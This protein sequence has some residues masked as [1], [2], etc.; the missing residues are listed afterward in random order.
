VLLTSACCT[1]IITTQCLKKRPTQLVTIA[2][3]NFNQCQNFFHR[4]K[5]VKFSTKAT[6]YFHAVRMS[7]HFRGKLQR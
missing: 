6:K 1:I 5:A 4:K 7:L 2:S 3:S